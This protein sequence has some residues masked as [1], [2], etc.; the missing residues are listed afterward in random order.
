[1]RSGLGHYERGQRAATQP[2]KNHWC[3]LSSSC[4]QVTD[5]SQIPLM[6]QLTLVPCSQEFPSCQSGLGFEFLS[7]SDISLSSE[8]S[9]FKERG[10]PALS[11]MLSSLMK[12]RAGNLFR[13]GLSLQGHP[14]DGILLDVLLEV[15]VAHKL[16]HASLA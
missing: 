4:P 13:R 10:F 16:L 9:A 11:R 7:L 2:F 14:V 1:M 5:E 8:V 15:L 3:P 12:V 6:C